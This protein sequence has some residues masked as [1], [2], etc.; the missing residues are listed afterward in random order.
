[1]P[2]PPG[3]GSHAWDLLRMR[4]FGAYGHVCW[5]CLHSGANQV[6]HV[7]P[8]TER[9]ELSFALSNLRPAHGSKNP[10]LTCSA[11]AGRKV[12]CNQLKAGMSVQR[13]RRLIEER[14]GLKIGAPLPPL[15]PAAKPEDSGREW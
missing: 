14:T 4:V 12:C 9:P 1:M 5:V 15:V 8:V 2:R 3:I 6:D 10:C 7:E 11:A 13:A